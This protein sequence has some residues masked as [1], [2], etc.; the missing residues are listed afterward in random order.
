MSFHSVSAFESTESAAS[1]HD[2]PTA[3]GSASIGRF[4]GKATS[5]SKHAAVQSEEEIT[6][7]GPS[8]TQSDT[9]YD[10][11]LPKPYND[12][13]RSLDEDGLQDYYLLQDSARKIAFLRGVKA[14]EGRFKN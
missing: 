10:P 5:R 7:A 2:T 11:D 14:S 4:Q 1:P 8:G 3:S 12:I 9:P 6:I 13:L